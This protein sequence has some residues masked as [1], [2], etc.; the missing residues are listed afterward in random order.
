MLAKVQ[1]TPS[2]VTQGS[3][4]EPSHEPKIIRPKATNI[5]AVRCFLKKNQSPSA[6]KM[7]ARFLRMVCAATLIV[8]KDFIEVQSMRTKKK[9]SGSHFLTTFMSKLGE[10]IHLSC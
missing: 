8:L 9:V 5:A 7:M 6:V 1:K 2:G 3:E 4:A 10:W